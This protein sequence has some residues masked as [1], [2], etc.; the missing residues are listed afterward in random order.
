MRENI[1]LGD[2]LLNDLFSLGGFKVNLDAFLA[3]VG[4]R[5][6][7]TAP[8]WRLP[9]HHIVGKCPV[10]RPDVEARRPLQVY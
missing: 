10:M 7:V 1:G 3:S 9:T 4:M 2:E 5:L 8:L 6:S